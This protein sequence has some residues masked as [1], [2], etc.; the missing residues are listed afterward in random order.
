MK[1]RIFLLGLISLPLIGFLLGISLETSQV[2]QEGSLCP[3]IG[4]V[5]TFEAAYAR[6]RGDAERDGQRDKLVLGLAP[7]KGLS[8]QTTTARGRAA[9]D[10]TN[11]KLSV[12]VVGL[13]QGE[14][15]E[16]WLV[17]NRPGPGKSMRP[18]AG[19]RMIRAGALVRNGERGRLETAIDVASL[20]DF[21]LDLLVV[22]QEGKQPA[23]GGLLYGS[24]NVFQKL[25]YSES[26]G[27]SLAVTR[28][29]EPREETGKAS[30]L[31]LAPLRSLIPPLAY[32]ANGG[33]PH[34][35]DLIAAGEKLFFEEK[36]HGNGRTC[37]TCHPA[38]N[39]FTIDPAYIATLP[40][41]DPLF[42]AEFRGELN[43]EQNGGKPFEVPQLMRQFGLILL[44]VDGFD[45]LANKYVLR[46]VPHTLGL[47]LSITPAT[48]DGTSPLKRERT[49]WDGGGAFGSSGTLREFAIGAVIQHFTRTLE[50]IP[51]RDFNFPTD[52]QLDA[53]E[54]FL[55]SLG[56]QAEL[57]LSTLSL[58]DPDANLGITIF[59]S[60]GK[61]ASCHFNAGANIPPGSQNANFKIGIENAPH[62]ADGL[63]LIRPRD[64]GFGTEGNITD[65]FG[66][67]S[68]NT[69][70][71]VEAADTPPFF[72]NNRSNTI[73]DAVAFY[74][75]AAFNT[76]P[77]GSGIGGITL[78]QVDVWQVS[79]FLRVINAL[80]NI[81]SAEARLTSALDGLKPP[82]VK[83]LL[84]LAV[85][86][87]RDAIRVLTQVP[88]SFKFNGLH[89]AA[90]AILE[91]AIVDCDTAGKTGNKQTRNTN[92]QAALDALQQAR[93]EMVN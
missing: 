12:D 15:F 31:V 9:L 10:L 89:P 77:D 21:Q 14:G 86:D 7:F 38:D 23:D 85:G 22:V 81:R 46:G 54:A 61:C 5:R 58:K 49:G 80:E 35:A 92:I 90:R 43:S 28:P 64:G 76:S 48:F 1:S 6:W 91:N 29:R 11:G 44:N 27:R 8:T 75:T 79:A 39:N 66:D 18:E 24:P 13:P 59:T 36:F 26:P 65:G 52:A 73:E 83:S 62:P 67:G 71:L 20:A 88:S 37:G 25:Y 19:D 34:L 17:H 63:G 2:S 53:I 55:L 47:G 50:R 78:G 60:S 3:I 93:A 68:F 45:D 16:V 40:K 70:S 32:A 87:M 84:G 74:S 4:N 51:G 82:Q 33:N 57:E 69:P 42:V 41:N 72:H 56:R 30:A